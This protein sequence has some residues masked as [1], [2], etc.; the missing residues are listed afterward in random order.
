MRK[1]LRLGRKNK[2]ICFV[3][4]STFRNFAR[5]C[6]IS[7]NKG[8][9]GDWRYSGLR[10]GDRT[11]FHVL[12]PKGR[13]VALQSAMNCFNEHPTLS[14]QPFHDSTSGAKVYRIC[15]TTKLLR[16]FSLF[17]LLFRVFVLP[18]QLKVAKLLTLGYRCKH[19]CTRLI[20]VLHT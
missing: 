11:Q 20:A 12:P 18:L 8:S 1:L 4:L 7:L 6:R 17:L 16:D 15:E 10:I 9:L 2:Q 5:I 13:S 3:L 14:H 19:H